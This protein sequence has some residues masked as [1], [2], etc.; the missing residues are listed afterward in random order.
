MIGAAAAYMSGSFFASFFTDARVWLITVG[1]V[2][3]T[4]YFGAKRGWKR[5][6]N[7]LLAIAF[8]LGISM[9]SLYTS[10]CYKP[11]VSYDGTDGSFMGRIAEITRYD[12]HRAGYVLKGRINGVTDARI[13]YFGYDPD[14]RYGDTVSIEKC[15]FR[16]PSNTYVFN[17]EL[18]YKADGIFLSAASA[19]NV[20]ITHTHT[21]FIRNK[22]ADF[23]SYMT[24]RLKAETDDDV[25]GFLAG[26]IFG[27]KREL[28][29]EIKT[30]LYRS[31]IGH[32]LAV[33][34]LHVSI[35]A[36]LLM[37]VLRKANVNRFLSY[38]IMNVMLILF[39]AMANY[40]VSAIRA[41][42]MMDI[43]HGARLFRRQNDSLNSLAAASLIIVMV[44]PYAIFD[45]GF[46]LSVSGTFG[47]AVFAPFMTKNMKYDTVLHIIIKDF[48]NA[49]CT[50][51]SVFPVSMLFFDETSIISPAA[52]VL[53]VPLCTASMINALIFVLTGGRLHILYPAK[54]LTGMVIAIS[55]KLAGVSFLHVPHGW[56]TASQ[57]LIFFGF[58]VLGTYFITHSGKAV[59]LS[60][61]FSVALYGIM[62][63]FYFSSR[64]SKLIV[65]VLGNSSNAAAVI[66]F[67]GSTDII[68]L[69][70]NRKVPEYV[71]KYL[72]TNGISR[73]TRLVLT[74]NVPTVYEAYKSSLSFTETGEYVFAKEKDNEYA[75]NV[76]VFD[77]NG[78]T[79]ERER[80]DVSYSSRILTVDHCGKT[81]AVVPSGSHDTTSADK[82]IR[83]GR[84]PKNAEISNDNTDI[85]LSSD[86][87]CFEIIMSD[88]NISIRSL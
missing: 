66:T 11:A 39:V 70:G 50:S 24:E 79:I 65:A 85:W 10:A 41:A 30:S 16:K 56:D 55:R 22:L 57:L 74:K 52:N 37:S 13:T 80:Y 68:D 34:G 67:N 58:F 77:D 5:S 78:F 20:R 21:R 47:I 25:G 36:L 48:M 18:Y 2:C 72:R 84:I 8:T 1:A 73:V 4:L 69:S 35:I 87:N 83:Y 6:D 63:V 27:E 9:Y 40:P 33:S 15:T 28:D 76:A 43:F 45:A 61:A 54:T 88:N 32:I 82:V 38:G 3:M 75:G 26:M 12:G 53:M 59:A 23:R 62:S 49:M 81:I 86:N 19:E 51:L 31:G 7:I 17:S 42:I 44:Q 46:L 14:A 29:S 64:N 71:D 60:A